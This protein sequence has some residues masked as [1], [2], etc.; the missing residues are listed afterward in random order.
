MGPKGSDAVPPARPAG[1]PGPGGGATRWFAA[2][3]IFLGTHDPETK[4]PDKTAWQRIGHNIDGECTT[5]EISKSNSS[6]ACKQPT[7]ASVDSLE[8]GDDCRDNA[9]GRLVAVGTQVVS[10]NFEPELHAGLLTAETATYLLRL[11]DLSA[12]PDDPYV[13]GSL[14]VN[15]PRNPQ[16]EKPPSWDGADQFSIDA[17]SVD[18]PGP[19]DAG[20]SGTG[21]GGAS[22]AG[23]AGDAGNDDSAV[24]ASAPSPLIDKPLFVFDKG[25]VSKNVWVSGETREVPDAPAAVRVRPFDGGRLPERHAGRRSSRPNTTKRSARSCRRWWAPPSWRNTFAPS[26]SSSWGVSRRWGG[27]SWTATCCPLEISALGRR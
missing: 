1:D 11:D 2:K 17:L 18:A 4:Q 16:F 20:D 21:E 15:V 12:E 19:G 9:A 3:T 14:Y 24:E 23:D 27:C 26:R 7:G 25:Y 6:A 22:D 5:L 13:R 8:D 10:I